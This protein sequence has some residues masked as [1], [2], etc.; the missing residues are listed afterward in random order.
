MK[1]DVDVIDSKNYDII[2]S[3]NG[4]M[5]KNSRD[6]ERRRGRETPT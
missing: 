2:L 6:R 3:E 5:S 1:V 4:H